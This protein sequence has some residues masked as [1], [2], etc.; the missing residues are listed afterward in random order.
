MSLER[1]G[2]FQS[3]MMVMIMGAGNSS[4]GDASDDRGNGSRGGD[5]NMVT[6]AE[7]KMKPWHRTALSL[8]LSLSLLV[9][10]LDAICMCVW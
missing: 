8:S 3:F 4:N 6:E 2:A 1:T 10:I 5:V 9:C 7:M